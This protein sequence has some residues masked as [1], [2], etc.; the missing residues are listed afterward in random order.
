MDTVKCLNC[1]AVKD[2]SKFVH[3][4]PVVHDELIV[5]YLCVDCLREA[6]AKLDPNRA[7]VIQSQ[8]VLQRIS[9]SANINV[10][11]AVIIVPAE[12]FPTT[13][14]TTV[15]V[16][17][18]SING[19]G[20]IHKDLF[21]VYVSD[22]N[23]LFIVLLDRFFD[24]YGYRAHPL[25]VDIELSVALD[26]SHP[27]QFMTKAVYKTLI[28]APESPTDAAW[29]DAIDPNITKVTATTTKHTTKY[30]KRYTAG[31]VAGKQY[32]LFI[33]DPP[34][35][36]DDI[37]S[38]SELTIHKC[39]SE[40]LQSVLIAVESDKEYPKAKFTVTYK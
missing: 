2:D 5:G 21:T 31:I 8:T 24:L 3:Y 13:V 15:K 22:N 10:G 20:I 37:V 16:M 7:D 29:L 26:E 33:T 17:T 19:V 4:Q 34:R 40:T 14:D 11:T 36:I 25:R 39:M 1:H 12:Y 6:T 18:L 32:V 30:T 28:P 35:P 38:D 27:I 23:Q 9:F